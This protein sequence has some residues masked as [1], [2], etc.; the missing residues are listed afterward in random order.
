[1]KKE[2]EKREGMND[3]ERK[4]RKGERVA[5]RVFRQRSQR[6]IKW[7]KKEKEKEKEGIV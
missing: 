7:E 6:K 1:M 4:K 5:F 3:E 2:K